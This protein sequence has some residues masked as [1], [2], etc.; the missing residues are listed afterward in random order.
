MFNSLLVD[1]IEC[2]KLMCIY[3]PIAGIVIYV[4]AVFIMY[5]DEE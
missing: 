5:G 2:L 1:M 4:L 3:A